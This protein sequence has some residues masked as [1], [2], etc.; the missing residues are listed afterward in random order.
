MTD[1]KGSKGGKVVKDSKGGKAIKGIKGGKDSKGGKTLAK[2][3]EGG[4]APAKSTEVIL[5]CTILVYP[6]FLCYVLS[7][8]IACRC[9][10]IT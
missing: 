7:V 2:S 3:T 8:V 5:W 9:V 4:K 6:P 1:D 10:W